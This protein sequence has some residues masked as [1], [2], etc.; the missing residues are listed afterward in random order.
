MLSKIEVF[1]IL[2]P[3]RYFFEN[4]DRNQDFRNF[5]LKSKFFL[6]CCPKSRFSKL[7]NEIEFISKMLTE[8]EIFAIFNQNW[9]LSVNI[10]RNR[11]FRNFE[12]KW[13]FF[14]NVD[15]NRDFWNFQAKSIFFRKCWP[16]S[17]SS[18]FL[19]KIEIFSKMWPKSRFSTFG[20]EIETFWKMLTE[21][22]N[23]EILN[24]NR[25][26]LNVDWN[27]DFEIL[28]EIELFSKILTEIEIFEILNRNRFFFTNLTETEIFEIFKPK[29]KF[30][31]K[32]WPK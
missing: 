24:R 26:F 18:K 19:T 4:V 16:N 14:A 2:N 21:I 7:K 9:N 28:T 32:Y 5:Q 17:R 20:T 11:D 15:R 30:F 25:F 3:S 13:N 22:E 31:R 27:R 10:Y 6:K 8:I 23:V 12:S 29:S 1:E